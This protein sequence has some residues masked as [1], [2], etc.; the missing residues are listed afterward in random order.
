MK[1]LLGET[2]METLPSPAEADHSSEAKGIEEKTQLEEIKDIFLQDCCPSSSK[3]LFPESVEQGWKVNDC[4][5]LSKKM[6]LKVLSSA[7]FNL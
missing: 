5:P 2:E 4:P 7:C 6:A 3:D 1:Q